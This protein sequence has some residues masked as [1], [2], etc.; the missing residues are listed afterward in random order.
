MLF[1][2]AL[3]R[4]SGS[5]LG[6]ALLFL[7]EQH[8][9]DHRT[10]ISGIRRPAPGLSVNISVSNPRDEKSVDRYVNRCCYFCSVP[11][12]AHKLWDYS[13]GGVHSVL[14]RAAPF[15]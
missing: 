8:V 10:G 3:L 15:D 6:S 5:G 12:P 2:C 1:C 4:G 11:S 7:W 14:L 9:N 13:T